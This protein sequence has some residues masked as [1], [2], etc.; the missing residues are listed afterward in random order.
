VM[1]VR[2][3]GLTAILKKAKAMLAKPPT[4]LN[5]RFPRSFNRS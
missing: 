1:L 2:E 4:V 3:K 5:R